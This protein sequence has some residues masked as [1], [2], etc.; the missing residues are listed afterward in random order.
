MNT[1]K[2]ESTLFTLTLGGYILLIEGVCSMGC[3]IDK[4]W[5][6]DLFSIEWA[7]KVYK[8]LLHWIP[9][10]AIFTLGIMLAVSLIVFIIEYCAHRKE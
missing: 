3:L 10:I 6:V 1:D 7:E 5:L 9:I 8:F 2:Y 4:F